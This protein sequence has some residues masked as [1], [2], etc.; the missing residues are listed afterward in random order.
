MI[1]DSSYPTVIYAIPSI[2]ITDIVLTEINKDT[3]APS[4]LGLPAEPGETTETEK[5]EE[6]TEPNKTENPNK[7]EESPKP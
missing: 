3:I 6:I 4:D 5:T 1:F 2:D 7:T